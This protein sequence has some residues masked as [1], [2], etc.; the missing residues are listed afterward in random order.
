MFRKKR[1]SSPTNWPLIKQTIH[2]F[3][4][5]CSVDNSQRVMKRKNHE[6]M[7]FESMCYPEKEEEKMDTR[8]DI[9]KQNS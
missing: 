3:T 5:P 6:D 2:S 7:R 8:T 1:S 9:A 4:Y